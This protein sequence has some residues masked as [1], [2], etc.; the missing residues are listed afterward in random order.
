MVDYKKPDERKVDDN[1]YVE[2]EKKEELQR[3]VEENEN[4]KRVQERMEKEKADRK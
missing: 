3:D 2:P 4:N 1:K